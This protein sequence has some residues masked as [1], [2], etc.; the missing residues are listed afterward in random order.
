MKFGYWLV[1]ASFFVAALWNAMMGF[2]NR[3]T[4]EDFEFESHD[5]LPAEPS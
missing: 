4:K 2:G 5:H 1:T 3:K